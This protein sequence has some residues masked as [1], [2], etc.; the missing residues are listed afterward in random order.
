MIAVSEQPP[1]ALELPIDGA[2]D[3]NCEPLHATGEC[4]AVAR[5]RDQVQMIPL[6]AEVHEREV[7]PLFGCG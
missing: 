7:E 4:W 5:L 1:F 6:H 3:A 2:G